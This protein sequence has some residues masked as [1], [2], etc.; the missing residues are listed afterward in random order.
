MVFEISRETDKKGK[1]IGRPCFEPVSRKTNS[2]QPSSA[3]QSLALTKLSGTKCF[4]CFSFNKRSTLFLENEVQID[5]NNYG[6][7]LF[8]SKQVSLPNI[9]SMLQKIKIGQ[10]SI[11]AFASKALRPWYERPRART[12]PRFFAKIE[13]GQNSSKLRIPICLYVYKT[14]LH[15][16]PPV[17][18][19]YSRNEVLELPCYTIKKTAFCFPIQW[20]LALFFLYF[21]FKWSL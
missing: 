21:F 11:Y 7:M 20:V 12:P 3:P 9:S 17:S 1:K 18:V 8:K 10:N 19:A 6:T 4:F 14:A 15:L 16:F 13:H 2:P 5:R